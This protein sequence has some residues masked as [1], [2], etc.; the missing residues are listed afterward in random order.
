[1]DD[2]ARYCEIGG[3]SMGN[4]QDGVFIARHLEPKAVETRPDAPDRIRM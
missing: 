1:M 2:E 3:G 4:D